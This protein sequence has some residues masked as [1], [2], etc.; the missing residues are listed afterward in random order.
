MTRD[1]REW[2]HPNRDDADRQREAERQRHQ[3]GD[4]ERG[5]ER[6][7]EAFGGMDIAD[8]MQGPR[9]RGGWQGGPYQTG[10][11]QGGGGYAPQRDEQGFDI[12][13][14]GSYRGGHGYRGR[15]VHGRHH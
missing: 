5:G 10:G 3:R 1:R 13:A 15:L 11:F 2:D 7:Y 14:G 12:D 8:R 4:Q 9:E 6:A